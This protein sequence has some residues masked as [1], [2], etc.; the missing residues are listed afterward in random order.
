MIFEERQLINKGF[1]DFAKSSLEAIAYEDDR[2]ARFPKEII[3][4]MADKNFFGLTMPT[5]Y[6]G[7]DADFI[8]VSA[9]LVFYYLYMFL[10][11]C[12][13]NA[14]NTNIEILIG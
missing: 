13:I 2:N 14:L 5:E 10:C 4:E 9:M 3:K 1:A 6:G 11:K 7:Y 12:V 8:S